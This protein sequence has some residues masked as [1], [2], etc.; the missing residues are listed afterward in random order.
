MAG[1]LEVVAVDEALAVQSVEVVVRPRE[2][3][4][5]PFGHRDLL[6]LHRVD[7]PALGAQTGLLRS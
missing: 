2:I 3:H 1:D 4:V 7:V 6:I 5:G